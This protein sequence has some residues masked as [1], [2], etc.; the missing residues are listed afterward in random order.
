MDHQDRE[1]DVFRA[2]PLMILITYTV[3]GI[4]LIAETIRKSSNMSTLQFYHTHE[5]ITPNTF[6]REDIS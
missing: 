1:G 6:L 3:L 2:S 5:M 4:A